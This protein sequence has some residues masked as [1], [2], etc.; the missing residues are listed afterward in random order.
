[1]EDLW[2]LYSKHNSSLTVVTSTSLP[3]IG[4]NMGNQQGARWRRLQPRMM[5]VGG[6]DGGGERKGWD[7]HNV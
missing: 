3:Q 5:V 4:P 7:S 1:V 2:E 6:D